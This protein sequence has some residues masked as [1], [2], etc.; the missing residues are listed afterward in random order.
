MHGE[1]VEKWEKLKGSFIG[2]SRRIV[3]ARVDLLM[4]PVNGCVCVCVCVCERERERQALL[5][6]MLVTKYGL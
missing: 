5:W 1:E 4:N 3:R 2:V 6:E